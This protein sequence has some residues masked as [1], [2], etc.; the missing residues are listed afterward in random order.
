M[1]LILA[2]ASRSRGRI[3][4][5]ARVPF[6]AVA[7]AIDEEALKRDYLAA[8]QPVDG[9]AAALAS[10]K[11]L[12]VRTLEGDAVVLGAD[13]ILEFS[14]ALISKCPDLVAAR[15]LLLRLRGKTHRL[16]SALALA[17]QGEIV[18]SHV[19]H[20]TLHMR[21]FSD[22]FLEAYLAAEGEALLAGVG[23]YRLEGMGAQLFEAVE[24]DYF[25]ILGLSLQPL[26]AELRNQGVIDT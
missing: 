21:P 2:S 15:Q 13:Q 5:D 22:A 10:A 14:G 8:G 18:W 23:C 6:T 3:L 1:N 19:S 7:A 20:A 12:H 9:V 26:L 16:I 4:R 25:C 24:G 11:A 17:R